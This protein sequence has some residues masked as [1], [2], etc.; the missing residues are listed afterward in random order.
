M[1]SYLSKNNNKLKDWYENKINTAKTSFKKL[2]DDTC[3]LINN[4]ED[5]II[6]DFI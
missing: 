2:K 5:F 3:N 4:T 1:I 6:N